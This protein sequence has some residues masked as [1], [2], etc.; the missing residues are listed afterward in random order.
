MT[1]R[2]LTVEIAGCTFVALALTVLWVLDPILTAI[3][4]MSRSGAPGAELIRQIWPHCLVPPEWVRAPNQWAKWEI[5]E[6]Y[7]RLSVVVLGWT[8]TTAA[9]TKRYLR[10]KSGVLTHAIFEVPPNNI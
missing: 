2:A 9:L 3:F 1:K 6:I 7:A 8:L 5:L 10:G 4:M